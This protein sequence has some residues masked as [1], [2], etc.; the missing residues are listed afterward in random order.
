MGQGK[1]I[2][3]GIVFPVT[4]CAG[5]LLVAAETGIEKQ[6]FPKDCGLGIIRILIG[7]I[8]RERFQGTDP[9]GA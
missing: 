6:L 5:D 4:G 3:K 9:K 1:I 2:G 8:Y 7:R